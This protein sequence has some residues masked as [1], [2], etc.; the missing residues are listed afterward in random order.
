MLT[1]RE[2]QWLVEEAQDTLGL[3]ALRAKVLIAV[4][5]C[6]DYSIREI[7]RSTGIQ[8]EPVRLAIE[9]LIARDLI[10]V[11]PTGVRRKGYQAVAGGRLRFI[12]DAVLAAQERRTPA[13]P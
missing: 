2:R 5:D 13:A 11:R 1:D 7:G 9:M 6:E 3:T 12:L 10:E 4:L 8:S